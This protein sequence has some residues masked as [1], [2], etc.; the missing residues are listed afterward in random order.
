MLNMIPGPIRHFGSDPGNTS[1]LYLRTTG[2]PGEEL[3]GLTTRY[4]GRREFCCCVHCS[5]NDDESESDGTDNLL[6]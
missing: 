1:Q 3:S 5:R 2:R 6:A 4:D